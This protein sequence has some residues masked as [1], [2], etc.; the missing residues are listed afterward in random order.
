MKYV[1]HPLLSSLIGAACLSVGA[2]ALAADCTTLFSDATVDFGAMRPGVGKDAGHIRP[3]PTRRLY[4]AICKAPAQMNLVFRA[5]PAGTDDTL[6]FGE[7]GTYS[8]RVVEARLDGT[9]VQ[10]ARLTAVGQPPS[11]AATGDLVLK[12]NDVVAPVNGQELLRGSR[13]DVTLQVSASVPAD[14]VRIAQ[15]VTF[16]AASQFTL[17]AR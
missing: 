14:A 2:S 5:T 13:L 3:S 10:L 8:V 6:K 17:E 4:S 12:A 11:D 1:L 15:Q 7:S 9:P 16:N